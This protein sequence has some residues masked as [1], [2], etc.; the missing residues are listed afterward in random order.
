MSEF[1]FNIVPSSPREFTEQ[2]RKEIEALVINMIRGEQFIDVTTFS[3][4]T[5]KIC[6][7]VSVTLPVVGG[8]DDPVVVDVSL[9]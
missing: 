2:E 1:Q 8:V 9:L 5:N 4:N 6:A 3:V 7:Q